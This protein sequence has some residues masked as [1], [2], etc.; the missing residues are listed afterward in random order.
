[1]DQKDVHV[2]IH[3]KLALASKIKKVKHAHSQVVKYARVVTMIQL[4]KK[5]LYCLH[6][7]L[8]NG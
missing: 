5:Y 3:E 4:T 1:M 6:L 7:D 8:A 2:Y